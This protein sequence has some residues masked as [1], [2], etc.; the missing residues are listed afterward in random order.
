MKTCPRTGKPIVE[1]SHSGLNT[2]AS[3]PKKFAFRKM[4][5]NYNEGRESGVAADVGTALHEA[6]QE[7]MRSR[8]TTEA[9]LRLA[10]FHPIELKHSSDAPK[11]SLEASLITLEHVINE[12][13]LDS[14]DLVYFEK[15]G[16][17]IPGTEV[18]FLVE[19]E[20]EHLVFHLRGLIDLVLQSMVTGRIIA[21]DIKTTTTQALPTMEA[22]YKWDWQATSY[23]I[24]LNG[25]LGIEHQFNVAIAGVIQ[26]DYE[27]KFVMPEYKRGPTDVDQYYHYLI[28]KCQ[29]MQRY[30]LDGIFPRHPTSCI[31]YGKVC[32]YHANCGASTLNDMQNLVNPSRKEG[33]VNNRDLTPVFTAQLQGV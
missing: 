22:K 32:H 25:L 21:A 11:Y 16:K 30:W 12:G 13:T 15:D 7:Y 4:I 1:I 6:I 2:F 23:G 14:Y 8:S 29:T 26:S 19:I 27:P 5:I 20:L 17:R 31:A 18:A 24:P 9:M 3:C 10:E 33:T 28:D